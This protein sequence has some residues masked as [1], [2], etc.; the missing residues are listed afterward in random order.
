MLFT[1]PLKEDANS[2]SLMQ[3]KCYQKVLHGQT[4]AS[5]NNFVLCL[6]YKESIAKVLLDYLQPRLKKFIYHN[7]VYHFQDE[8]YHT[9]MESFPKDSILFTINIAKDYIFQDY[10]EIQEMHRHSFQ[11]TILVHICYKWNP[12]Y[13]HVENGK[14]GSLTKYHYYIFD[15]NNHDT[16]FVQHYF[17]LHWAHLTTKGNWPNKHLVWSNG[18]ATQ[19]KSQ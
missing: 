11:I 12:N 15:D 5:K 7:Y 2:T 8:Q 19:F 4:C 16:L 17:E 3:W 10:H 9:C 6:Q 1:C 14:K 18:C 13:V